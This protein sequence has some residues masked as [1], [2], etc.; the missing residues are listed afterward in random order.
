MVSFA[1]CVIF[2]VSFALLQSD[3]CKLAPSADL[4]LDAV[5]NFE[6]VDFFFCDLAEAA[7][8]LVPCLATEDLLL[9]LRVSDVSVRRFTGWLRAEFFLTERPVGRIAERF[10]TKF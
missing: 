2:V 7:V 6:C 10:L 8:A 5:A 9:L 3:T 4:E 1:F